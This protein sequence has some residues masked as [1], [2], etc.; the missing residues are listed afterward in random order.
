MKTFTDNAQREWSVE[1]NVT[2][3]KRIRDL[4]EVDLMDILGEG[5]NLMVRLQEDP[6]LLCNVIYAICKPQADKLSVSDEQF[7]EAMAGDAIDKGMEALLAELINFIPGRKRVLFE[8][9]MGKMSEY[10]TRLLDLAEAKLND[11]AMDQRMEAA[12]REALAPMDGEPS[13]SAPESSD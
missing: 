10:Q 4:A 2:S 7:G 13:T 9:A 3:M 8:K 5:G 12:M 1:L 6:I 11:P